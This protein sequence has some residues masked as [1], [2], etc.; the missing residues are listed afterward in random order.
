MKQIVDQGI[1][2]QW[3]DSATYPGGG[4]GY[5]DMFNGSNSPY[6]QDTDKGKISDSIFLNYWFN[7]NMLKDSAA[8]ARVSASIRN[9]RCL[10]A[11][12]PDRR[13]STVSAAMRAI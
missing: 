12:S 3:Y 10:L 1:Y 6:V 13:S 2:I 4:V 11:S 5:Q 8:H 7:G 9:M